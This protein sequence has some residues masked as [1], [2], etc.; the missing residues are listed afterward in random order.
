MEK[1]MTTLENKVKLE[2]AF[3]E[4]ESKSKIYELYN[5]YDFE[6]G[7]QKGHTDEERADYLELY[8]KFLDY[9]NTK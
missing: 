3:E 4:R 6:Y 1:L 9:M 8:F 5:D 2:K 7:K